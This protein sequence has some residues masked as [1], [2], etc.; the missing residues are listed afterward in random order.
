MAHTEW[1]KGKGRAAYYCP[2]LFIASWHK[3]CTLS[4]NKLSTGKLQP[5]AK[6]HANIAGTGNST[7]LN[8]MLGWA[9]VPFLV[10]AYCELFH[11]WL[12][13][14]LKAGCFSDSVCLCTHFFFFFFSELAWGGIPLW[15]F[16]LFE[17]HALALSQGHSQF[18]F[19]VACWNNWEWPWN[20]TII[21]HLYNIHQ[22]TI[23]QVGSC[24]HNPN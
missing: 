16:F 17:F 24:L 19:N 22:I 8:K 9:H 18:F 15:N 1:T 6:N 7:D 4:N 20:E 23:F 21:H 13:L 14:V 10:A 2:S 11:D 5:D 3:V 12:L